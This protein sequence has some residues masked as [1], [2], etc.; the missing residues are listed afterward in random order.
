MAH[1]GSKQLPEINSEFELIF[2]NIQNGKIEP[3]EIL[4]CSLCSYINHYLHF[5]EDIKNYD[6]YKNIELTPPCDYVYEIA[7]SEENDIYCYWCAELMRYLCSFLRDEERNTSFFRNS[8]SQAIE[9]V[10]E[11]FEDLYY[12]A[13]YELYLTFGK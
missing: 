1:F 10:P 7:V 5:V 11:Y 3:K 2:Y 6:N 9:I 13:I 4:T 12:C 8:Y